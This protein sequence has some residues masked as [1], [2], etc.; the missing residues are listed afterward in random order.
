MINTR[1]TILLAGGIGL[2]VA[3]R[4]GIAQPA[5][6]MKTAKAIGLTIPQSL[7]QRADEVI[8]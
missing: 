4:L 3:R 6:T 1:R 2:L 7:L 5:S 8:Q